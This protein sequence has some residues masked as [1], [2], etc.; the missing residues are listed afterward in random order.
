MTSAIIQTVK[1]LE[2]SEDKL[3]YLQDLFLS[4][5]EPT[6]TVEIDFTILL[7]EIKETPTNN[8]Q[9]WDKARMLDKTIR[10]PRLT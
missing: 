6:Q 5:R 4:S 2:S 9:Y 7:N 8:S 1:S 10:N 3:N